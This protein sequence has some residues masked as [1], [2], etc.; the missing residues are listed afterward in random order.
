MPNNS[1]IVIEIQPQWVLEPEALGSKKKFWY[2]PSKD[3]P[4]W[5]FKFPQADTGQHWAE[6][7]A[8]EVAACMEILHA[9]VELAVFQGERGS[10]TESFARDGGEL[11]HGNQLLA[12]KVHGYNPDVKFQ[13]SDHTL[14]NIF[15]AL[16]L[17]F[18]DADALRQAKVQMAEY[19]VLDAVVGNTDR[20]H[21]NWGLL[22]K[23]AGDGW[24]TLIAPSFDHASSLGRELRDEGQ[25]KSRTRFVAEDKV[26][27]YSENGR[28]GVY[29][30]ENDARGLSPLELIR[31]AHEEYPDIFAPALEKVRKINREMLTDL[32]ARVPND[33]MTQISREFA[34]ALMCY[35][36]QQLSRLL[37]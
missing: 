24:Q 37:Q 4:V 23:R 8:A 12:G 2:R 10:A 25:R 32:I 20:H 1:Y 6:K 5:L 30:T 17:T 7:I 15:H 13:Q 26:G 28:G 14:S 34:L 3:E 22:L 19:F 35:N 16:E 9:T 21:E 36:C 18:Q 27:V 11:V 29:W 33:W 31:R